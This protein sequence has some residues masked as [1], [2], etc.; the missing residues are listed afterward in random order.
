[1]TNQNMITLSVVKW[2]AKPKFRSRDR[3]EWCGE[4]YREDILVPALL[5]NEKV[6]VDLT[7]Y[8]RYGRS[9]IDE[10][11]GGLIRS[12]NFTLSELNEKLTYKH[13]LLK[14]VEELIKERL[15]AAENERIS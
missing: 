9:F 6:M 7:G 13:D 1:M 15:E 11:F 12:E 5:E 2:H 10:T 4:A 14:S 8:N 3:Y